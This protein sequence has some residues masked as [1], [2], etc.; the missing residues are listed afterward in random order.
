MQWL[1]QLHLTL[2]NFLVF[3]L[4][5]ARISGLVLIGPIFGARE[6]PP[7]IRALLV[8]SLA[9]VIVPTQWHVAVEHPT[10]LP[11]YLVTLGGELIVG[12]ALGLG[13]S[14]LLTSFQLAGQIIAQV[15]GTAVADV[16][17]PGLDSSAPLVSQLFYMFALAVFIILGGHRLVMA[18]LLNTFAS[19]PPGG[20][21]ISPTVTDALVTLVAESFDLGFR[22]AAP[23]TAALLLA[24]LVMGLISRTLPQLN[25]LAIGFGVN[26]MVMLATLSLSL[27]AV[28]W[29]IQ[30]AGRPLL[31]PLLE[32][33]ALPVSAH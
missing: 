5:V 32:A 31:E 6:V 19:I 18:G 22:V 28:A 4:V 2:D 30:D 1:H 13:V 11:G 12:V 15:S 24:T 20:G 9:L 7:Q 3:T 14:I 27:A 23:T 33:V 8:L 17:N 16:F 26:S 10:T 29:L 21:R 25:I